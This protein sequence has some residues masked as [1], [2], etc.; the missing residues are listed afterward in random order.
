[1][2]RPIRGSIERTLEYVRPDGTTAEALIDI[3]FSYTSG[4]PPGGTYDRWRG[5]WDPPDEPQREI[6][7]ASWRDDKGDWHPVQHG[8]WLEAWIIDAFER[9]ERHHFEEALF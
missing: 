4:G 2:P 7:S 8:E 3:E 9:L 5:G 6:I 1:M